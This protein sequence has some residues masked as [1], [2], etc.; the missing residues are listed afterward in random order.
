MDG[1]HASIDVCEIQSS[2]CIR[3]INR[4][5]TIQVDRISAGWIDSIYGVLQ[6]VDIRMLSRWIEGESFEGIPGLKTPG[7]G[8]EIAGAKMIEAGERLEALCGI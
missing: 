3:K 2:E 8:I 7:A 4:Q 5:K 6:R 1:S